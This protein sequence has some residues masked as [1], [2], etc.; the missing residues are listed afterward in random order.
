M[1]SW[2]QKCLKKQK[3]EWRV[4]K[5]QGFSMHCGDWKQKSCQWGGQDCQ[6]GPQLLL[7]GDS[8]PPLSHPL[9]LCQVPPTGRN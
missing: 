5:A 8:H 6:A 7:A 1:G 4:L 3:G 2:L 9:L